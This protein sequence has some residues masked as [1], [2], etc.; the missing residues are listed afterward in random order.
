MDGLKYFNEIKKDDLIFSLDSKNNV[1][2]CKIKNILVHDYEGDMYDINTKRLNFSIT[3]GHRILLQY[4]KKGKHLYVTPSEFAQRSVSYFPHNYILDGNEKYDEHIPLDNGYQHW[5]QKKQPNKLK[6]NDFFYL[7]GLYLGDGVC[8][9]FSIK[10]ERKSRF[11]AQQYIQQ[12]NSNG[13]FKRIC[14]KIVKYYSRKRIRFCIP[15]KDKAREMLVC[16]LKENG[17]NFSEQKDVVQLRCDGLWKLFKECGSHAL[18]K[19]IPK[20]YLYSHLDNRKRLFEGLIDSDGYR[21]GTTIQYTTVSITLRDNII[22]LG[23]GL[24]YHVRF[25]THLPKIVVF[26]NGHTVESKTAY[27]AYFSKSRKFIDRKQIKDRMVVRRYKGKVWC[28]ETQNGNF[29]V[30][31]NGKLEFSGNS[32]ARYGTNKVPFTEDMKPNPQDPYGIGKYASELLLKN[33]SEVHGMEWVIAVPHNII[34]PRQ[35]YDDPYRNVAAIFINAML[36]GKQP[37]IYGD[38]EQKRCFS[39]IDEDVEPLYRMAF[40]NIA[41]EVINIGPDDEFITINE[42]AERIAKIIGF[43]LKPIRHAGRPQEVIDANCSGEKARKLFDYH[44]QH[45]LDDVLIEMVEYVKARGIKPFD[46]HLPLEIKNHKTPKSWGER[47]Y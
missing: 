4:P 39:P 37:I 3:P 30:E 41:G 25:S 20:K 46:Y 13:K 40:D 45:K 42:L 19:H 28:L 23:I 14:K 10:E 6:T 38:G 17:F 26:K 8:D 32:M 7:L 1:S 36:Q 5:N 2:I 11:N 24:G 21:Q 35:K 29:L 31:R 27:Y 15:I 18:D 16:T 12:R 43:E 47:L 9:E 33:L 44:P 22:V 34:G